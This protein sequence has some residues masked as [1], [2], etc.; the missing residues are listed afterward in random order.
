MYKL[1]IIIPMYNAEKYIENN[2]IHILKQIDDEVEIIIVNDG[3]TDNSYNIIKKY[4]H[5]NKNLKLFSQENGGASKARNTGLLKASGEYVWFIDADDMIKD[6]CISELISI[7]YGSKLDILTFNIQ[8][9]SPNGK[10]KVLNQK[11]SSNIIVNAF[12]YIKDFKI[13]CYSSCCF[14]FRR[15]LSIDNNA[16]FIENVTLEDYE[17]PVKLFSYAQR[18]MHINKTYYYYNVT[19]TST[20][21]IMNN[22][23]RLH[24]RI[25]SLLIIVS[26]MSKTF[27]MTKSESYSKYANKTIN[28][29]KL[30]TL[31]LLL[32]YKIDKKDIYYLQLCKLDFFKIGSIELA[33]KHK[34]IKQILKHKFIYKKLLIIS[35]LI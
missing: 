28:I 10:S 11:Q 33:Y 1:S 8:E 14:I 35:N 9:N 16:F 20:S 15:S 22:P 19:S 13:N 2:I 27:P 17:F 26:H 18:I 25:Q 30:F 21:R 23:Q 5:N 31:E 6:N 4:T 12:T 34:F 24:H 3:S 32:K 29:L 7:I